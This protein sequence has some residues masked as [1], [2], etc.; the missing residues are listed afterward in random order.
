MRDTPDRDAALRRPEPGTDPAPG[1]D[2][3]LALL[4]A[5]PPGEAALE[6]LLDRMERGR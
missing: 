2:D 1:P 6:A 3:L 4:A 5:L